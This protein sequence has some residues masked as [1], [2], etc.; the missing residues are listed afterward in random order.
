VK[1]I[2]EVLKSK[3]SKM[4]QLAHDVNTLQSAMEI[5]EEEDSSNGIPAGI[6]ASS[7]PRD[8]PPVA[9]P[10]AKRWP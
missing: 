1:S 10:V 6:S 3:R 7:E 2:E 5:L 4:E 8:I 9:Q